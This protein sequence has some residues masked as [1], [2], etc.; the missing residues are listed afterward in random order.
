MYLK[1]DWKNNLT[2]GLFKFDSFLTPVL[3]S[4]HN[5][6]ATIKN[7]PDNVIGMVKGLSDNIITNTVESINKIRPTTSTPNT[8]TTNKFSQTNA[9]NNNL[10]KDLMTDDVIF[11]ILLKKK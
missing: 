10:D 5:I 1:T 11:K 2:R 6:Q 3:S 8:P 9:T 7:A 4:V